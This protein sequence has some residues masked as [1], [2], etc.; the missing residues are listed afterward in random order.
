VLISQNHVM[1]AQQHILIRIICVTGLIT[2]DAGTATQVIYST[3]SVVE[4]KVVLVQG[5]CKIFS[6]FTVRI[7][8]IWCAPQHG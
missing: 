5:P 7:K 6:A 3:S 8:M 1:L 4:K 2:L